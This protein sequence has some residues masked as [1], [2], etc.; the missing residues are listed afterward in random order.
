LVVEV[1]DLTFDDDHKLE[2]DA[3]ILLVL[4]LLLQVGSFILA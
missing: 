1:P 4:V 2:L 3:D